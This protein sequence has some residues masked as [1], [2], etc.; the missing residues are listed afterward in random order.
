MFELITT[1]GLKTGLELK[2]S[3][4]ITTVFLAGALE[5][6]GSG[7]LTSICQRLP[8]TDDYDVQAALGQTG[9]SSFVSVKAE[10]HSYNWSMMKLLRDGLFESFDF[11]FIDR[12]RTWSEVGFATCLAERLLKPGGWI[13]LD[14]LRFTFRESRIKHKA[15]VR[16]MPEDEQ[17]T[18][19]IR[20]VFDLLLRESPY[21]GTFRTIGSLAFSRKRK[22]V[23]S[24]ELRSKNKIEAIV[25]DA[26]ERARYDPEFREE[27]L[28]ASRIEISSLPGSG[29]ASQASIRF[30]DSDRIAPVESTE[31]SEGLIAYLDRPAW[32]RTT[33][34][35][36]LNNMLGL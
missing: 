13:V 8:R 28:S 19:Q 27:L 26:I 32:E 31:D 24:S 35:D 23:W 6:V 22:E 36:T 33:D 3:P 1:N 4:G 7:H 15:W 9:L 29:L 5:S 34:E 12:G 2:A 25:C 21:F 14:N 20:C 10:N 30:E 17:T 16:R 18:R 11:C